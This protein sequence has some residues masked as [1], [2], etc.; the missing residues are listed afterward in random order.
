MKLPLAIALGSFALAAPVMAQPA[1]GY[2]A[3]RYAPEDRAAAL[4]APNPEPSYY[5]YG[6]AEFGA[7]PDTVP[8]DD[9][10]LRT[11]RSIAA[12]TQWEAALGGPG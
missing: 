10:S 9:T 6:Y 11:A 1:S 3:D 8:Y 12:F 4:P 2:G 7:G 5:V